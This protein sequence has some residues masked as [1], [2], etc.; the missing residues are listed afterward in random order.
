MS[1]QRQLSVALMA[2][3]CVG[4]AACGPSS[5]AL[6]SAAAPSVVPVNSSPNS[7]TS[8]PPPTQPQ[9]AIAGK[10][11]FSR[12]GN[13]WVYA[14]S[15]AKQF[16]QIG[17]AGDPA[18]S[19]DGTQLA[20]D[21]QDK[22]SAD[23][24]LAAYPQGSA[25]ALSNNAAQIVENNLWDM[26]PD[27]SADGL[28]LAYVSDRARS[29]TGILDPAAWRLT[30]SSRNRV[31]LS[32]ANQYTGGV[33]F[34]R[35]RPGHSSELA[36]TSWA[37]DPTTLAA[38]GQ[39]TLLDTQ[40]RQADALTPTDQT[41]FQASW[42]PDGS[43]LVFIKRNG[44]NDDIWIMPVNESGTSSDASPS[45]VNTASG[46]VLIP[47]AAAHPVWSPDG[48][49]IAYIGLKDG[50]LDLFVQP[51]TDSLQP[52]GAPKQLTSGWHIEAASAI[53]WGP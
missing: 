32:Q 53:S 7:V 46:S 45:G 47:G 49:A 20:F 25:R 23:L 37:Y 42:S 34:P 15:T 8:P 31:Q 28:S 10:I 39:L 22:N 38:Y 27:W 18:W 21:K 3:L 41:A 44:R 19:P 17:S 6:P 51:L 5:V 30:L 48:H 43:H 50:S 16:T 35:W 24:Y 4:L 40:T 26:Q 11:A 13:I 52:S 36:Y 33:D 1:E 9:T 14:G 12:D 29:T 2:A